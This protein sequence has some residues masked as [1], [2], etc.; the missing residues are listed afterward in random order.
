[1]LHDLFASPER[2]RR[3]WIALGAL[4][5]AQLVAFWLLC[6]QQVRK[7]ESRSAEVQMAQTA[8]ADCLQYIPG[9]TI[10]SCAARLAD[11]SPAA[12]SQTAAVTP[13]GFG[14]YR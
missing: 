14:G 7:A 10:A 3:L 9:A 6:S 12:P 13:V 5:L 4:A 1:M 8:L 11:N 2:S